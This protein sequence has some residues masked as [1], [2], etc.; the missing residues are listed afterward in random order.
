M[1]LI[2]VILLPTSNG[3]ELSH[4]SSTAIKAGLALWG[5]NADALP[6]GTVFASVG[7]T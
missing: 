7:Q 4:E 6:E 5:G 1:W 2:R 3:Y